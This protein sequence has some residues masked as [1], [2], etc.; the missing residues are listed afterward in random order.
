MFPAYSLNEVLREIAT[1]FRSRYQKEDG[2][3]VRMVGLLFAPP[4]AAISKAEILPR[5]DDFHHRSG[6]NI[7]FFCAGYGAYWPESWVSDAQPVTTTT[8]P[9]FGLKTDWLYSSKYFHD[10]RKEIEST[11][12]SWK[13][14][15]EV[16]LILLNAYPDTDDLARLDFTGA[17]VLRIDQLRNDKLIESAPDL[18][19][20]IFRYAE[21]QRGDDPTWGFSDE[22]GF[23]E[24]RSWFVEL[25][26]SR[27]PLKTGELWKRGSHYAVLN[28]TQ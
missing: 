17:V 4:G 14:S 24:S 12:K 20:K 6:N 11:A 1:A 2:Q 19:E 18:L 16:D 15:G 13:Y 26:L 28:L 10:F 27:L 7:D 25:V 23:K 5:L 9:R 22:I 21:G 8:D 3:R